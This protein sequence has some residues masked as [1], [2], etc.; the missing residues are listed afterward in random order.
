MP[1]AYPQIFD[2]DD[3]IT[4]NEDDADTIR[5]VGFFA[6]PPNNPSLANALHLIA[7][8]KLGKVPPNEETGPVLFRRAITAEKRLPKATFYPYSYNE[9]FS[10]IFDADLSA[11]YG[12]HVWGRSWLAE[13]LIAEGAGQ[14][15]EAGDVAEAEAT[16]TERAEPIRTESALR[17]LDLCRHIRAVRSTLMM[18][19]G[20]PAM[21]AALWQGVVG[22]A[23]PAALDQLTAI[24]GRVSRPSF[25]ETAWHLLSRHPSTVVW[26]VGACDGIL[27]DPL[28][29]L[30]VNFDP[31]TV[32]VEPHPD[33]FAKLK[34]NYRRNERTVMINAAVGPEARDG[35]LIAVDPDAVMRD[36]LP[37]WAL[38]LSSFHDDRNAL[39]GLTV[40][41]EMQGRL[42][43]ATRRIKVPVLTPEDIRRRS[44]VAWPDVLVVDTEG[45]DAEVVTAFLDAGA[46][47]KIIYFET[48]C[49]PPKE[50]EP[51][52]KR[53]SHTYVRINLNDNVLFLRNDF[54]EEFLTTTFIDHG[55]LL[56]PKYM[57]MELIAPGL[58]ARSP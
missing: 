23:K 7:N 5:S 3:L 43:A 56:A 15:L 12:I 57:G 10:R 42:L 29:P 11:T 31:V 9:P 45:S 33:M 4:C 27:A 13:D 49:L 40:T 47:P 22:G 41:K 25:F 21:R 52:R 50:L 8:T 38:G 53:L 18:G 2:G 46:A 30:I 16:L 26:Q 55:R 28:R 1:L 39:G 14:C 58:A 6:A 20:A 51:L 36:K 54:L 37:H 24:P 17:L 32:M 34:A 35:T 48:I 19:L 44:G